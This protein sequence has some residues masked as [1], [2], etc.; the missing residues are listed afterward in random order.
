M[1]VMSFTTSN[2]HMLKIGQTVDIGN[3]NG[4]RPHKIIGISGME[5]SIRNLYWYE[6]AWLAVS[7][8]FRRKFRG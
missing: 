1:T 5:V 3:A 2:N 6:G 7:K 4:Y 8:W